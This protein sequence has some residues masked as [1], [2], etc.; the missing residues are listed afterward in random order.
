MKFITRWISGI[1]GGVLLSQ[2]Y[3]G[4]VSLAQ[5]TLLAAHRPDEATNRAII[6]CPEA[7]TVD[8]MFLYTPTVG[9]K[10]KEDGVGQK[11]QQAA[12]E[13]N[14]AL[15]DSGVCG[16]VE[17]VLIR[18]ADNFSVLDNR[19]F[20]DYVEVR[21]YFN[22]Q[23]VQ[24]LR[25]GS[26]ADL[27]SLL[28][29]GNGGWADRPDPD[30]GNPQATSEQAYSVLG[31]EWLG[32]AGGEDVLSHE[33]GHNLGASHDWETDPVRNEKYPYNKGYIASSRKWRDIMAYNT[34]CNPDC[35]KVRGYSNPRLKYNGESMGEE[36]GEKPA[37]LAR[38]FNETIPIVAQYRNPGQQVTSSERQAYWNSGVNR[39][40]DIIEVE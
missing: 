29:E 7:P 20:E 19:V 22:S 39:R 2:G 25:N 38:L 35:P 26:S 10:Y 14:S 31:M 18:E 17:S 21:N 4:S 6:E 5:G 32:L 37:D 12:F 9:R 11:I 36:G 30:I 24:D 28:Y 16:R 13:M 1:L 40:G 33:V 8:I 3:L 27:V 15:K 34:N 23:Y